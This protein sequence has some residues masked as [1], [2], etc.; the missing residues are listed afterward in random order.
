[1]TLKIYSCTVVSTYQNIK[2]LNIPMCHVILM[3]IVKYWIALAT[4]AISVT[5]KCSGRELSNCDCMSAKVLITVLSI[6]F[7]QCSMIIWTGFGYIPNTW[8]LSV[9]ETQKYFHG[10]LSVL[11]YILCWVQLYLFYCNYTTIYGRRQKK[12][13]VL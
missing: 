2:R 9:C 7:S 10:H 5:L 11:L 4:S 8:T 6:F 1:M 13:N 3:Y 12:V